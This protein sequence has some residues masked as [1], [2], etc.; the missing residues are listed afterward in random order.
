MIKSIDYRVKKIRWSAA[1]TVFPAIAFS[2]VSATIRISAQ[3][4]KA[5]PPVSF[6]NEI[7]PILT[8][9]GCN[10]G[11]CHGSQFG[12]GGFKLTLAGYDPDAD[13]ES[14]VK[15]AGGR[16]IAITDPP[17]SLLLKKPSLGLAHV[18]GLKLPRESRDYRTVLEWLAQG[19]PGPNPSDPDVVG[20]SVIPAHLILAPSQMQR[21]VVRATYSNGR[22]REVT[23]HT[24]IASLNESLATVTPEGVVTAMGSGATAIMLRYSGR[25][26]VAE[27]DVPYL[28]SPA[29]A[30]LRAGSNRKAKSGFLAKSARND[31]MGSFDRMNKG[32]LRAADRHTSGFDA[33]LSFVDRLVAKRWRDLGL[34][35]SPR[36]TDSEFIRRSS[37]DIIGTLP[38]PDEVRAFLANKNPRKRAMLIDEL[39]DRPEY[40]DYWTLKWADLLRS[41]RSS[42][43]A[44]SMSSL[45]GW[46][47]TNIAE[48][49]PYDEWVRELLTAKGSSHIVGP[50]NY[51]RSSASP[52]DL[53]ETTAQLFLGQR[54]QCAK[55]HHHPFEKW[56]QKD[57][58]QFAAFFAR[59]GVKGGPNIEN[60]QL[61]RVVSTGEV[62]HPKS[63]KRM[64]PTPL[65]LDNGP[66]HAGSGTLSDSKDRREELADW[67]SSRENLQFARTL[68]NRY[69]GAL[70]GRGIV[71]PVDDMRV[72]NP[73]SNPELLD[74][75]SRDFI[76]HNFDL[77]HVLRTI[78]TSQVYQRSSRPTLQN[79]QDDTFCSH[80][81]PKRMPAEV[82]LDSLCTATG[83]SE[84][85]AGL[86]VGV[87]AIQLPDSS[88]ASQF[89]DSF[90]RP[91][92]TT[93][94]E[95]ERAAEPSLSQALSL[96]SG[97]EVNK[98][99]SSPNGRI[100]GLVAAKKC[101]RE[102]INELYL[103]AVSRPPDSSEMA[104]AVRSFAKSSN[105]CQAAED[106][107]WAI[108][109]TREFSYIR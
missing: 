30:K 77:K 73:P 59:V 10:Q 72:T 69:W 40:V 49:R 103:A 87:R 9:S 63:G 99:L 108:L 36:C 35:P 15:Q 13:Y 46:I 44:K 104:S 68:V 60:D 2:L 64:A 71:N 61:V 42:L 78:C 32:W 100:A 43:G 20:L 76:V 50:A 80:Y 8:H 101:D 109:N 62:M 66:H 55:C 88:V 84:K 97:A 52:Q 102:I 41:S 65:D 86:P 98:K 31:D 75:L 107:L 57:Y 21:L 7:E 89:L 82:M 23:R 47:R 34:T 17:E 74:A 33:S 37:L 70:L 81:L 39:L 92:R 67:L 106:L 94:C 58:Y 6:N 28:T 19:A 27:I 96:L 16:R 3:E 53:T 95:C 25:V 4:P 1:S 22:V 91:P 24:R 5:K 56:S 51:F 54:L 79:G 12:K 18:G 85:Y 26:A 14:I 38:G 93:S 11:A 90:G 45:A 83:V 48:N 105:Q 29:A